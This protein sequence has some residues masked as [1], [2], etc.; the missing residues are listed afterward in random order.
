MRNSL[1]GRFVS[2]K[3]GATAVEYGLMA[4]LIGLGIVAA[5]FI[6]GESLL[7]LY[8]FLGEFLEEP[9]EE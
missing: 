4:L 5:I 2:D 8:E 1:F 6:A 7:G 3:A 9:F